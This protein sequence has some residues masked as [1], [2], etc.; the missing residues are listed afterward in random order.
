MADP[1]R[2]RIDKWLWF[3]RLTKTRTLAQKL[4]LSG[5]IRVNREKANAA[6]LLLKVG[7]VLT[8]AGDRGVRV[9]KVLGP[10][11][12]RGPAPEARTLYE[13]LS[14]AAPAD[15]EAAPAGDRLAGSGRPTKRDRRALD[16][17]HDAPGDD[18]SS[19]DE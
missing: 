16:R 5:R 18:F 12:R 8:I 10:G 6:S 3:A 9:L 14:P 1:A 11:T 13:D 15:R 17:L 2:Q 4:V 7:D 19:E